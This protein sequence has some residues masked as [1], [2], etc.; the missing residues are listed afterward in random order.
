[1]RNFTVA[2]LLYEQARGPSDVSSRIA[3]KFQDRSLTYAELDARSSELDRDGIPADAPQ[4]GL[5]A[6]RSGKMPPI[7]RDAEPVCP[8]GAWVMV[9]TQEA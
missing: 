7:A 9:P 3:L 5:P 4:T 2:D 6:R 8:D 1:M